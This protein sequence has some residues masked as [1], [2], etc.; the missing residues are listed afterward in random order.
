[1]ILVG[2]S[3]RNR[4]GVHGV[5]VRC[6]TTLPPS[7]QGGWNFC[8]HHRITSIPRSS[9]W[10][11]ANRI[12]AGNR[13]RTGDLN[14]GKVALY[15]LSYSR[16]LRVYPPPWSP[17]PSRLRAPP[18]PWQGCALPTELFP[19]LLPDP[20]CSNSAHVGKAHILCVIAG[21]STE[22]GKYQRKFM[23]YKG[24]SLSLITPQAAFR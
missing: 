6:M 21:M 11:D 12:G 18:Q 8:D 9:H 24:L 13:V 16:T 4:T 5:A 19:H 10:L 2:G 15:Q 14:L 17:E 23:N 1:M 3:G 7:L 20:T 22:S